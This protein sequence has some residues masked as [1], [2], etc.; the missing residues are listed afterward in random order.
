MTESTPATNN[1]VFYL[2]TRNSH[3]DFK[4]EDEIDNKDVWQYFVVTNQAKNA[5]CMF[6]DKI[7][8]FHSKQHI[9]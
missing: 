5:V 2:A 6:C 3:S 4:S 8:H 9:S 1:S 7:L